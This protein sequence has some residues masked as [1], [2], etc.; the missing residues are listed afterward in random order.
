MRLTARKSHQGLW[1]KWSGRKGGAGCGPRP[2]ILTSRESTEVGPQVLRFLHVASSSL[3]RHGAP[4]TRSVFSQSSTSA[5]QSS[6]PCPVPKRPPSVFSPLH[7]P[8]QRHS[9]V[10]SAF[11]P[12]DTCAFP[13][14]DDVSHNNHELLFKSRAFVRS[15]GAEP[16]S[17]KRNSAVALRPESQRGR[18]R[19][20][21]ELGADAGEIE[22][23][24]V[25]M[26]R[27][28]LVHAARQSA[29]SSRQFA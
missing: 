21:S 19:W 5:P 14:K 27:T 24:R 20:L 29:T 23:R 28:L 4:L 26:A 18:E 6:Y 1:T 16:I 17:P 12:R 9:S 25:A 7:P 10:P 2:T 8:L 22:E 13:L 3:L 11:A 15:R